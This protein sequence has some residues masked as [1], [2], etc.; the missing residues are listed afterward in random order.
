[1][2]IRPVLEQAKLNK[3]GQLGGFSSL[4]IQVVVFAMIVVVGILILATF[5]NNSQVGGNT[6]ANSTINTLIT[7][8]GSTSG[9]ASYVSLIVIAVVGFLLIRLVSG[10]GRRA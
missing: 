1:M 4:A 7:D 9:L 3:K 8:L 10:G 5:G 2:E 6:E